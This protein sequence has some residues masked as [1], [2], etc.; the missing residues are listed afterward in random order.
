MKKVLKP[1]EPEEVVYYSDF[2]GKLLEYNMVPVTVK[3]ECGYGS[4]YDGSSAELHLTDKGLNSL[5]VYLK[6]RLCQETKE[7]LKRQVN[8]NCKSSNDRYNNDLLQKLI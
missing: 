6:D 4:E 5:L 3:I 2:S 8:S 7:E 1:A